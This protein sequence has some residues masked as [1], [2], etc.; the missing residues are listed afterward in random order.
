[1]QLVRASGAEL[2]TSLQSCTS[3]TP[4]LYKQ[5]LIVKLHISKRNRSAVKGNSFAVNNSGCWGKE[6]AGYSLALILLYTGKF[7][8]NSP[9]S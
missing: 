6:K 4:A 2:V 9:Q 1:M 3:V 8:S 7:L 5:E